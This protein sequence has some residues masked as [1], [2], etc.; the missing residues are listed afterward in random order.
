[1]QKLELLQISKGKNS[2][3]KRTN[4]TKQIIQRKENQKSHSTY[5]K[6][7]DVMSNQRYPPHWQKL[8]SLKC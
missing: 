4:D 1:M 3:E 7:F 8:R 5:G 6:M 2:I